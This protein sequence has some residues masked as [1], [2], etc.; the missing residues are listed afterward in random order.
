MPGKFSNAHEV[1]YNQQFQLKADAAP[2]W[3]G[4]AEYTNP[5]QA[6]AA[7]VSSCHLMTFLALAAK[8]KWPVASFSDR[9]VAYLG[10]NAKGLMSVTKID[11]H[12]VVEFDLGFEVSD[13]D[14]KKMHHRAH[15]YCFIANTL[16][17]SVEI[18]IH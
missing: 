11:L 5:E 1:I 14:L 3:G 12:P 10:K 17:S 9:A 15:R 4:N 18:N 2:D 13:E 7:A 8:T 6:L 16:D